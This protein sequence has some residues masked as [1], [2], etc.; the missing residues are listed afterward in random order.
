MK[1]ERGH[2]MTKRGVGQTKRESTTVE[3]GGK[4]DK[5]NN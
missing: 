2:E 5:E 3:G 1:E 4:K